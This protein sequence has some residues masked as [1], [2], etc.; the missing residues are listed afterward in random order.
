VRLC[1]RPLGFAESVIAELHHAMPGTLPLVAAAG[2]EGCVD[3]AVARAALAALH[4]RHPLLGARL[5]RGKEDWSFTSGVQFSD[6]PVSVIMAPDDFELGAA[7]EAELTRALPSRNHLWRATVVMEATANRTTLLLAAHHAMT[8]ALALISLARQFEHACACI[9]DGSD[10][11]W[12]RLPLLDSVEQLLC[13]GNAEPSVAAT[14]S[15]ETLWE[16]ERPA[17]PGERVPGVLMRVLEPEEVV[18]LLGDTRHDHTTVNATLVAALIEVAQEL[19]SSRGAFTVGVPH[20]ARGHVAP[21]L[22]DEYQAFLVRDVHL[23]FDETWRDLDLW[24]RAQR[25]EAQ[26]LERLPRALATTSAF[27]RAQLDAAV[28][29]LLAPARNTFVVPFVVTNLGRQDPGADVRPL[30][31]NSFHFLPS[32]RPGVSGIIVA[33]ATILDRMTLTFGFAEPLVHRSSATTFADAFL[34]TLRSHV[35]GRVIQRRNRKPRRRLRDL[36]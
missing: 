33:V 30:R 11:G 35:N 18:A 1:V 13:K 16:F 36:K 5:H 24:E 26:Y 9:E 17:P 20:S 8:D 7:M 15:A 27:T 31:L 29:P 12:E 4:A 21:P 19:P 6:V 3:A 10:T 25:V 32:Q 34:A 14:P 2:F 22:D 23:D 28:A